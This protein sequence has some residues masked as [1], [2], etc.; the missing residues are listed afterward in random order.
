MHPLDLPLPTDENI[1]S[2][3]MPIMNVMNLQHLLQRKS[4]DDISEKNSDSKILFCTGIGV[5][6]KPEIPIRF[7]TYLLPLVSAVH[8]FEESQGQFY[9]ADQAAIRIG[10]DPE[11]VRHNAGM[12][13]RAIREFVG[14]FFPH[15]AARIHV[16]YEK[17]S[18]DEP[19][20][21]KK[22]RQNLT[23]Q[24]ISDLLE[25]QDPT[26]LRFARKKSQTT[27]VRRSLRY[28]AEHTLFMRDPITTDEQLFL[29]ENPDNF[30][31]ET[32]AMIG[33]P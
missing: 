2:E 17:K 25:T 22:Q 27:T 1:H 14:T 6:S 8:M 4:F 32:L 12:M 30:K 9:I 26:I 28:M 21:V 10:Y 23:E 24:L 13:L 15:I 11:I 7:F 31:F 5:N 16:T 19:S 3:V 20:F 18:E 29:V 33:G